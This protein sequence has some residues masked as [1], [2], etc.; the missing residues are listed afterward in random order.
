MPAALTLRHL[1]LTLML[2]FAAAMLL[3]GLPARA[4]QI[5]WLADIC[6]ASLDAT[7]PAQAMVPHCPDCLPAALMPPAAYVP[8]LR[9]EL[10]HVRLPVATA[11]LAPV[12]A[13]AWSLARGPPI[14]FS[15]EP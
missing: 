2:A 13:A 6:T 3:V 15:F 12:R 1:R 11:L 7:L 5:P 14:V 8:A 9:H 10:R 4:P